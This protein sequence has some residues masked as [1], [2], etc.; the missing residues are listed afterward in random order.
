MITAV[1]TR[2]LL[3]IFFD[4]PKFGRA[5]ADSLRQ[6][7]RDGALH[8]CPAVWAEVR[9]AFETEGDFLQTL[10]TLGVTYSGFSAEAAALSGEIWQAYRRAGGTRER[11]MADFMIGAHALKHCDRLLTRDAGFFRSHF[12]K[13]SVTSPGVT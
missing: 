7:L 10:S 9:A 8:V 1:D 11:I 4:D 2:I 6:C 3:D 13:L 12:S 5:S